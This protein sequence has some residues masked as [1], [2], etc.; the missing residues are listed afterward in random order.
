MDNTKK[1]LDKVNRVYDIINFIK[2][3]INDIDD[4][5]KEVKKVC[6][7]KLTIKPYHE[8]AYILTYMNNNIAYE[9]I[10]GSTYSPYPNLK[11][12]VL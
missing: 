8:K 1:T 11:C 4:V 5:V 12:F 10:C 9:I 6:G 3:N 7:D 2:D